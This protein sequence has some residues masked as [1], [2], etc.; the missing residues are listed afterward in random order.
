MEGGEGQD[1]FSVCVA[2]MVMESREFELVL[3]RIQPDGS[4]KPGAVDKFLRDSSSLTEFVAG[5]AEAQGLYEDAVRLYDLCKVC[6]WGGS[7]YGVSSLLHVMGAGPWE[8]V[9]SA[10]PAAQLC[11]IQPPLPPVPASPP[12]AA[13]SAG[14]REVQGVWSLCPSASCPH[15]LSATG[16][17]D[18]L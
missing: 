1:V 6:V 17:H 2:D 13:G 4:R 8:G 11:G 5:Q 16:H 10:Q 15:L 14:G 9:G 3:G 18:I 7:I 12:A